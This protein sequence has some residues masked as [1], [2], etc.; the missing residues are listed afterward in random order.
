MLARGEGWSRQLAAATVDRF[1]L[2]PRE[3]IDRPPLP[4]KP[5]DTYPWRMNRPLSYLRRPLIVRG[6]EV[7]FGVKH[8]YSAQMHLV[9][10]IEDGRYPALSAGLRRYQGA[11]GAA[12]GR[13][14][15]DAVAALYS[16]HGYRALVRVKRLADAAIV[17]EKGDALGDIDVLVADPQQRRLIAVEAKALGVAMNFDEVAD[18]MAAIFGTDS[19]VV[20]KHLERCAWLE[21]NRNAAAAEIGVDVENW[22]VVPLIVT[23][24]PLISPYL[25]AGPIPV[26]SYNDLRTELRR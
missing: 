2:A 17:D 1:A 4:F 20:S 12:V 26:I 19:A 7:V 14:F 6:D 5:R 10:Q 21:K 15:E 25:A 3:A 13:A 16:S 22:H 23:D 8:L 24:R 9:R 11:V 18:E